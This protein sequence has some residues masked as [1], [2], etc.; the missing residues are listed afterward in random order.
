MKVRIGTGNEDSVSASSF[1]RSAVIQN[2]AVIR[3]RKRAVGRSGKKS[4]STFNYQNVEPRKIRH[5]AAGIPKRQVP[6]CPLALGKSMNNL[7]QPGDILSIP[8]VGMRIGIPQ[9]A[10]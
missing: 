8:G 4:F 3:H 2:A 1:Y 7:G 6:P 10:D 5:G 9:D